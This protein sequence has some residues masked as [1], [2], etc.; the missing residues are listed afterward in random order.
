MVDIL[1]SLDLPPLDI[2]TWNNLPL[3]SKICFVA[4]AAGLVLYIVLVI[5]GRLLGGDAKRE[6][7]R[8]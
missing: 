1:R 4:A 2:A 8:K 6:K 7:A 5:R 3:L